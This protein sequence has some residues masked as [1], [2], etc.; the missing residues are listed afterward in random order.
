MRKRRD[1]DEMEEGRRGPQERDGP[2]KTEERWPFLR[3]TPRQVLGERK[4]QQS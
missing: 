4:T 2:T 1:G 3:S